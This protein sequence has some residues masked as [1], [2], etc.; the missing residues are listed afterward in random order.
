M[1]NPDSAP[2]VLASAP[3]FIISWAAPF[4]S[5]QLQKIAFRELEGINSEIDVQQYISVDPTG[6]VNHTKQFGMTKPPTVTLRRGLDNNLALWQWHQLALDGNPKARVDCVGLD[7]YP[8]W[9]PGAPTSTSNLPGVQKYQPTAPIASYTLMNAWCSRIAIGSAQAGEGIVTEEVTIVCDQIAQG[10]G[11]GRGPAH[12]TAPP[13][14][15][16]PTR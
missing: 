8:A 2:P 13:P 9:G 3:V 6:Y 1:S 10:H 14:T 4:G 16:P 5:S 7:I 12:L 11:D 15:L